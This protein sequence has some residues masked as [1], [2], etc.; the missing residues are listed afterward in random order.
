MQGS[1]S[2]NQFLKLQSHE[3]KLRYNKQ[4]S[5]CITLLRNAKKKYCTIFKMSHINDNKKFWKN[6]KLIFS[7]E[8]K[9]NKIIALEEGNKM[10][11]DDGKLA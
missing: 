3:S 5:V 4:R 6:I 7:N 11:T 1:K 10:I 9:G 2:T 8:N